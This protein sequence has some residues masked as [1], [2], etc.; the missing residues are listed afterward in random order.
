MGRILGPGLR[1]APS[2]LIRHFCGDS[3]AAMLGV[4]PAEWT[5]LALDAS[6]GLSA[7]FGQTGD[8]AALL[9]RVSSRAGEVLL[10]ASSRSLDHLVD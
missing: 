1:G 9:S 4:P 6:V 3:L 5:A 10:A 2:T 8:R 7:A